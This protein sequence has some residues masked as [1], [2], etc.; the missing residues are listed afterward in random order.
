MRSYKI[1]YKKRKNRISLICSLIISSVFFTLQII[2]N[3]IESIYSFFLFILLFFGFLLYFR[4]IY[5]K[6]VYVVSLQF[7]EEHRNDANF[8]SFFDRIE[9]IEKNLSKDVYEIIN[10]LNNFLRGEIDFALRLLENFRNINKKQFYEI[11]TNVYRNLLEKISTV[12]SNSKILNGLL[13]FNFGE[14]AKSSKLVSYHFR[15]ANKIPE[16][17]FINIFDPL[18]DFVKNK[19][20][21]YIDDISVSGNQ[22]LEDWKNFIKRIKLKWPQNYNIFL[23][24]NKFI[25]LP[26]FIS[27]RAKKR[28]EKKTIFYVVNLPSNVITKTFMTFK[29]ESKIFQKAEINKVIEIFCKYGKEL[30]PKGP[31]GYGNFGLL[32]SFFFNTPNNTLPV[33][34]QKSPSEFCNSP[35]KWDPIFPRFES[36]K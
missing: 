18:L 3:I 24:S 23:N 25:F 27:K 31:L 22:M 12:S 6:F 19:V 36:R 30:Y 11:C 33:I 17:S 20:L 7:L 10:W 35:L 14:E 5:E 28:I 16:Q 9:R 21:I 13:F 34:W 8:L 1:S 15:L 29:R 26:I 2:E 4:Y 32:M